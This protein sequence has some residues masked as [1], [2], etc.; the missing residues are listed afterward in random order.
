MVIA[1]PL[2]FAFQLLNRK[3]GVMGLNDRQI[4][5]CEEYLANGNNG[6]QAAISAGYSE[7]TARQIASENLSKL[8][9]ENYISERQKQI[10]ARLQI[11]QDRVL[12]ELSRLAFAD[13]RKFYTV[14]GALKSI[15]DLDEDTA[16]SLAGV[17]TFDE[18]VED[19][20]I[21]TTKKIKTYDKLKAIETLNRMLGYN[22]PDKATV[23]NL[24]YN[25]EI[26]KEEA[27]NISD[28][29]ESEV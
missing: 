14:D 24:N 28:A 11:N 22:A 16:A 19:E 25:T 23:T 12:M 17:E 18:R 1:I 4:R 6:T 27:K 9:I 20:I 26:S 5:F 3:F 2:F 21:G 8:D 7:D 29:L 13:I 15:H 10:A